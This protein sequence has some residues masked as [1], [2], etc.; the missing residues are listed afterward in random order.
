MIRIVPVRVLV[1][2]D[3]EAVCRRLREWLGRVAYETVAFTD[4]HEGLRYGAKDACR[5]AL[6]DLRL[7]NV[8]GADVIRAL[9]AA[10]PQ[11]RVIAMCAFPEARQVIAAIRAGAR[12]VLEKP[13]QP[14]SLVEAVERQ[15][16]DA[17]LTVRSEREFNRRLGAR[18]RLLRTKAD[19]TLADVA[20]VVGLTAAQ[21][22]QIELGKTATST[23]TLARICHALDTSIAALTAEL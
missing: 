17:G 22:S 2:D 3:E 11:T 1:I 13:I 16:V 18:I 23:W 15:L 10:A 9:A 6:V 20:D 21:L 8:D 19:R 12:D 14:T 7:P 5:V 4:P